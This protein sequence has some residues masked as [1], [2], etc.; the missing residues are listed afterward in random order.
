MFLRTLTRHNVQ[1]IN[2]IHIIWLLLDNKNKNVAFIYSVII[3]DHKTKDCAPWPELPF[4]FDQFAAFR[5]QSPLQQENRL[6]VALFGLKYE[7]PFLTEFFR[8]YSLECC[9]FFFL[10]NSVFKRFG[11]SNTKPPA[12]RGLVIDSWLC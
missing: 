12:C 2:S 8:Q 5:N 6:S 11:G 9:Y 1:L 7:S 10:L 4:I 3:C